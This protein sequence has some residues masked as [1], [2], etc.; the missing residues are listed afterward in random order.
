MKYII[1]AQRMVL[2][3]GNTPVKVDKTDPK[4]ARIIEQFSL[5]E[6]EQDAAI[7]EV[8]YGINKL[9]DVAA[10]GFTITADEVVYKGEKLPLPL[11][12]KIRAIFNEGLPLTLFEKF[13]ENLKDNPSAT[14]VN[15]LYDF[16]SYKELPITEDGYFL[17]YKGVKDDYYSVSGNKD[18][19]VIKGKVDA[20]GRIY[21]GIGETVAVKRWDVDDN[22]ENHCSFGLHAGSLDYARSFAS[23]LIIVK[24]NPKDVVSVPS[25]CNCQKLRCCEYTVV[26]DLVLE[27]LAPVV[28]E[29]S[30][31]IDNPARKEE[32]TSTSNREA[33][34]TRVEAYLY[35]KAETNNS[36]TVRMIQNSFSPAHPSRQQVLDALQELSYS[37]AS[38]DFDTV[39]L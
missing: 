1:N 25:D 32:K 8:L 19:T 23:K 26:G 33:F 11:A 31:P 12:R 38:N 37:W 4:Y 35:K 22:R 7:L 13:W 30:Q 5:P 36:V 27:I 3:F 15:E 28:D 6:N 16:L 34:V 10:Q 9:E 17:A 18:T 29:N 2:F 21:N 24:I 20:G 39:S 14:S